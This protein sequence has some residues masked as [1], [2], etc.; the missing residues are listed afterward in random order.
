MDWDFLLLITSREKLK[1]KHPDKE[2]QLIYQVKQ[3]NIDAFGQIVDQ[4]KDVSLSL[5]VSIL[6]NKESAEDVLQEV[7]IKVFQKIKTFNAK[8]TFATWLYRIVV[9]TSY[10][11]LKRQKRHLSIDG[12]SEELVGTQMDH[13][14]I[15]EREAQKIYINQALAKMN[16]DEAL[17]LRLF[18]L[19][20]LSIKEI[21]K[22]TGFKQSKIKV[23]LHR[24][25]KNLE[26]QL[27]RILGEEIKYLL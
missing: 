16:T 20:E 4:Y 11:E 10:N 24:G 23:S 12:L 21:G 27:K 2:E 13:N 3:G 19:G 1:N 7:F 25:R 26:F 17:V 9:N 22:V 6:K 8:S 14:S 18:Y 5:A 15:V